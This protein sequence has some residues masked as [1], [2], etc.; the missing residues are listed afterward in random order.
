M[1][2]FDDT[3]AE[4]LRRAREGAAAAGYTTEARG[5]S[6]GGDSDRRTAVGLATGSR[7]AE[8]LRAVDCEPER[9]GVSVSLSGGQVYLDYPAE[10]RKLVAIP[11]AYLL[12]RTEPSDKIISRHVN[13]D[14]LSEVVIGR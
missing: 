11:M 5:P 8:R 9:I 1:G 14:W 4:A 6:K 13:V 2:N 3:I 10:Y 7:I 12:F